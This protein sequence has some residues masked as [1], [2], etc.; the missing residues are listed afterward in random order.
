MRK[1]LLILLLCFFALNISEAQHR[2]GFGSGLHNSDYISSLQYEFQFSKKWNIS[3]RGSYYLND[4]QWY[5]VNKFS[6]LESENIERGNGLGVGIGFVRSD[7]IFKN[8]TFSASIDLWN[9]NM[10][11]IED[12]CSSYFLSDPPPRGSCIQGISTVFNI[13][14]V[15]TKIDL[16]YSIPLSNQLFIRPSIGLGKD[17]IRTKTDQFDVESERIRA[18]NILIGTSF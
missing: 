15:L 12:D 1:L 13:R 16:G 6:Y 14:S 10:R 5:S 17:H 11:F 2:I 8:L 7:F 4:L 3:T 18:F 9:R